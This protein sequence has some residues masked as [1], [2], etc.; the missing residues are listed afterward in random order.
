MGLYPGV[1]LRPFSWVGCEQATSDEYIIYP[2][3]QQSLTTKLLIE[4]GVFK[5]AGCNI[6]HCKGISNGKCTEAI[7]CS[8]GYKH[9]CIHKILPVTA[10]V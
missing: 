1:T 7:K 3:K 10:S 9:R 5:H 2:F 6:R 8:P 4:G